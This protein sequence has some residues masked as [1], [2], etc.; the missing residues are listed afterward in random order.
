MK[1]TI[2]TRRRKTTHGPN[3]NNKANHIQH[4]AIRLNPKPTK[5]IKTCYRNHYSK[6]RDIRS[7]MLNKETTRIAIYGVEIPIHLNLEITTTIRCK[8][9][10]EGYF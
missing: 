7:L 3:D 10:F 2:T 5:R 6:I 4:I 1:E 9:G 8:I